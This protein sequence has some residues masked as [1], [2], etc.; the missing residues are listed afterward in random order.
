MARKKRIVSRA[1]SGDLEA[2]IG[3][4]QHVLLHED[5][6]AGLARVDRTIGTMWPDLTPEDRSYCMGYALASLRE[7]KRL[8][9]AV[10]II[11]PSEGHRAQ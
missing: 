6:P 7:R 11:S 4:A 9:E 10:P 8:L 2:A 5:S 1:S 3:A